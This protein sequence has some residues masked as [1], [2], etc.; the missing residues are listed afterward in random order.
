MNLGDLNKVWEVK[1]L[2]KA[3]ED[4]ARKI[5]ERVAKHVQPIMRKHKWRVK[6]LSEF[7]IDIL[8]HSQPHPFS[9]LANK[10]DL[11]MPHAHGM[12][13]WVGNIDPNNPALLGLNVGGGIHVKLRLRRPNRDWDFFP[14]DQI[15]DTMLHE[16]CHNVHGPH[17][18]DFYKLWDEIRK[19]FVR[20]N[21]STACDIWCTLE[22]VYLTTHSEANVD[23]ILEEDQI[24]YILV[25]L[26][27][28]CKFVVVLTTSW[29]E[30][31]SLSDVGALFLAHE[32]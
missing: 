3:G 31:D 17:N 11:L 12:M 32:N 21:A 23:L 7:W 16:L 30:P 6:L 25:G 22:K 13:C 8:G 4:E 26:S 14:F 28:E 1:P 18:A 9:N 24:L 15:L 10:N 5:L 29:L 19:V 2:K 20:D 27:I